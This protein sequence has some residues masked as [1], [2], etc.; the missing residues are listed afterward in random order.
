MEVRM[1]NKRT[2]ALC[3]ILFVTF[4]WGI[5]FLSIKV[6]VDVLPP[7][8]LSFL[9]F[10]MALMVLFVV[11][12]LKEPKT[13]LARE[14]FPRMLLS[15]IFGLTIYFFCEN[16]GVKLTTAST[17]SIIIAVLPVLTVIIDAAAFGYKLNL[18]KIA[19]VLLSVFGVCLVV[20]ANVN[21]MGG[22]LAGY[23]FMLGSALAWVIYSFLTKPLTKKYSGLAV[24]YYQMVFGAITILPF[25]L[26]EKTD[27]SR[28]TTP[29]I[30]NV[31]FLGIMC[32]ALANFLYVYS[33]ENL[34]VSLTSMFMNVLP[35]V[36]VIASYF[37]LGE[38]IGIKQVIGGTAVV[39]SVYLVSCER[40]V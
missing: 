11:F 5:S 14:D 33:M 40:K 31:L 1:K 9:R 18:M 4:V 35:L 36:T 24:A 39:A 34:G 22:S 32:S 21:E 12:K 25:V 16:T 20:N 17:A 7:M 3:A 37:V 23:L 38:K 2:L 26:M 29:I 13:R 8:T 19:G 27:W 30:L 15:G 6:A 28:V 10:I